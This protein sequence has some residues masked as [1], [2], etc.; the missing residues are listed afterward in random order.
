[1]TYSAGTDVAKW[2][3][4]CPCARMCY[5]TSIKPCRNVLCA[6]IPRNPSTQTLGTGLSPFYSTFTGRGRTLMAVNCNSK[7]KRADPVKCYQSKD[8]ALGIWPQPGGAWVGKTLLYAN[9]VSSGSGCSST[10]PAGK[11]ATNPLSRLVGKICVHVRDVQK[12]MKEH[13]P[14][15]SFSFR[16]HVR[17]RDY[18]FFLC[19]SMLFTI[20]SKPYMICIIFENKF[21]YKYSLP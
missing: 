10:S 7:T 11:L 5:K 9:S 8:M 19:I 16:G 3:P 2:V 12:H 6:V 18:Y 20:Y 14:G 1:M 21:N 15:G 17:R 4:M 13:K